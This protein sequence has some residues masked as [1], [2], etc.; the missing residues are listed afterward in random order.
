VGPAALQVIRALGDLNIKWPQQQQQ[1]PYHQQP[2]APESGS[3]GDS[4]SSSVTVVPASAMPVT[5]QPQVV[6]LR[7][8]SSDQFLVLGTDG[9]WDVITDQEAVGLVHDTVKDAAL[10]AKRLVQ[11]G[12]G[13]WQQEC[14]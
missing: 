14:H 12:T 6:C 11:E 10:C 2:Y 9:L 1:Q 5:A 4:S 7:L 13:P 3:S 8:S